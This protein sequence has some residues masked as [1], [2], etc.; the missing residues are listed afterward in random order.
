MTIRESKRK[1][2]SAARASKLKRQQIAPSI[3]KWG[4]GSREWGE[5]TIPTPDSP[6]PI[7]LS[8]IFLFAFLH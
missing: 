7:F 6:L 2:N 4:V 3:E 8:A 5:D 1:N